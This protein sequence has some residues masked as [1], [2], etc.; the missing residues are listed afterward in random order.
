[1]LER[2]EFY[3]DLGKLVGLIRRPDADLH[4]GP[5]PCVVFCAGMSLTKEVWLP[6][7]AE[8]LVA[9]GYVTLNFDYSTFGESDGQPRCRLNCGQQVRDVRAAIT[10]MA[11]LTDVAADRIGLYG[12]SLGASVAVATAGQDDRVRA[13]VAVAGPM[14]LAR[15][16]RGFA[17]FSGFSAKVDAARAAFVAGG[18]PSYIGVPRL[19]ASDPETAALLQSEDERY[20]TWRQEVTF[21]SLADLFAFRPEDH[22]A[23][24][25]GAL[26]FVYPE[27]DELIARFEMQSAYA[28]ARSPAKLVALAG[29]HHVDVYKKEG[30]FEEV[31]STAIA[32]FGEHV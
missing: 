24:A 2:V 6:P 25:R 7:H 5:R 15:V 32:W 3:G 16:W 19:L 30:A 4:P 20:P 23:A 26:C 1:M 8:R 10:Y 17:G 18:E 22:A 14:D 9:A 29:A 28:R 31:V 11:E 12:V 21:E 13:A 27:K